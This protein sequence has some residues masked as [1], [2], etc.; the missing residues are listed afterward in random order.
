MSEKARLP[1]MAAGLVIL[2]MTGASVYLGYQNNQLRQ[3]LRQVFEQPATQEPSVNIKLSA[4]VYSQGMPIIFVIKNG[5]QRNIY[6]FPE[7]CASKLV[8]VFTVQGNESILM[9]GDPKICALA[10]PVESLKPNETI[11]SEIPEKT[12]PKMIQGVYKITF[13]YSTVKRDRFGLGE[14][15]SVASETFTIY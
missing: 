13:E 10:P 2:F 1:L 15:S 9:D 4:N 14:L 3:M 6:Y 12:L 11:T 7:T 5:T 8:K